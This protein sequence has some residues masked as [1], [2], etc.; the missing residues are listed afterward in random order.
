[1]F[2]MQYDGGDR[3]C[4]A[5]FDQ[6]S[7]EGHVYV[8][9]VTLDSLP[10]GFPVC[11]VEQQVALCGSFDILGGDCDSQPFAVVFLFELFD[12]GHRITS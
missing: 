7:G 5:F 12:H 9:A 6:R 10:H 1:M 8:S 2:L 4:R 3:D 11:R